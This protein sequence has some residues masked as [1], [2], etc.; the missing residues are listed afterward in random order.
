MMSFVYDQ[1]KP[2]VDWGGGNCFSNKQ[3]GDFPQYYF[4]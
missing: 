4:E 2:L 3:I 1:T